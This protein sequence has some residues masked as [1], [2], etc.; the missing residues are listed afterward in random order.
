M[1]ILPYFYLK[2]TYIQKDSLAV[3]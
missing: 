1:S 2:I 3:I